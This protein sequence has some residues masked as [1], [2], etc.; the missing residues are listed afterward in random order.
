MLE[1]DYSNA[2]I[3]VDVCCVLNVEKAFSILN[4][5]R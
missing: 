3:N 1:T 2:F 5:V 4:G